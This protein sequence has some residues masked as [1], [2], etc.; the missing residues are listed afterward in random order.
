MSN[1]IS[2]NNF[3]EEMQRRMSDYKV[4]EEALRI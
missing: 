1:K 2:M 4:G 3:L